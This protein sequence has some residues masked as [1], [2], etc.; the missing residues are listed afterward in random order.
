[1]ATP[2]IVLLG[3]L[4][5]HTMVERDTNPRDHNTHPYRGWRRSASN[6]LLPK[7]I[8]HSLFD[9][10]IPEAD[11]GDLVRPKYSDVC[12]N[13][14]FERSCGELISVLD[15]FPE[16]SASHRI[17]KDKL[18]VRSEF[19]VGIESE[20][21][22]K[23]AA[24][25]LEQSRIEN[26]QLNGL[27]HCVTD[28]ML[29]HENLLVLYDHGGFLRKGLATIDTDT[30]ASEKLT[31]LVGSASCGIVVGINGDLTDLDWLKALHARI[32]RD[33]YPRTA[34]QIT[35]D[36]LRKRGLQI[37]RYGALEDTVNDIF[38]YRN[39]APLKELFDFADHLVIVFSETG[40]LYIDDTNH[41][42]EGSLHFC[43]NFDRIAQFDSKTYGIMPGKF[44]IFL[45][46]L[47]KEFFRYAV[48]KDKLCVANAIR[49]GTVAYNRHF[50]EG[51]G[52]NRVRG[53]F[54]PFASFEKVLSKETCE[55]LK[56][57]VQD[58]KKRSLLVSSLDFTQQQLEDGWSRTSCLRKK[59]FLETLRGIIKDGLE[60]ELVVPAEEWQK[61]IAEQ[62]AEQTDKPWFPLPYI[63]APYAAMGKLKLLDR[64]EIA[65][66]YSLAKIL[67]K[68]IETKDWETPLSIAVFGRP[69]S[70]KSFGVTQ[71]LDAV[72]PGRKGRPLTFNLAQFNSVDQLTEAFHQIQDRALSSDEVPLAI[73]D[74]F[75][76]QFHD[77]L[78]W[79]KYFLAPMQDGLFRGGSGDYKVGRA[80]FL[81]AGGT[82]DSF[83]QFCAPLGTLSSKAESGVRASKLADFAS[84]LRGFL[85]VTDVNDA[86]VKPDER[87]LDSTLLRRAVILRSLL[88][89]FAEPI[90]VASHEDGIKQARIH[91]DVIDAFLNQKQYSHGVRSMEA[92]IQMSRWIEGEFVPASLP[93]DQLL[94]SHVTAPFLPGVR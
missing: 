90:F 77:R 43:P 52:A 79:L 85:D 9:C 68:Y 76:A 18:R 78:G 46:A 12:K 94:R 51:L 70:G 26:E 32:P 58:Q 73:F 61:Q 34:V 27:L 31:K 5:L 81:F 37:A 89:K 82:S 40:G 22:S 24:S 21:K 60:A 86:E 48:Y 16:G 88:E 92:I 20:G 72:D 47:I 17:V 29:A 53:E 63:T 19:L 67:R 7:M 38:K 39:R 45:V 62:I 83:R 66:H 75:D 2:K 71:I 3:D 57:A 56:A 44:S 91:D 23:T 59:P 65:K 36:S 11:V 54:N 50:K 69:G 35:A 49:L 80:I 74:E 84:R 30:N 33:L 55:I 6:P 15:L 87:I 41:H 1:M 28:T 4:A 10:L 64:E 8:E 13:P 93:S 42:W 14:I 25:C